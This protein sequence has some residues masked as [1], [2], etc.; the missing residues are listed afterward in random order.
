VIKF[1]GSLSQS[2]KISFI[3]G[4]VFIL[5]FTTFA[6]FWLLRVDYQVLFSD[7]KPQDSAVMVAELDRL[8]TPYRISE[9]G[10]AILVDKE[11]VHATRLKLLGKDL[12]L[13][14]V[15]GL[16]LFN[17]SDF[18]MT[19][20][21]QKINYQR[22]LQGEITRTISSLEEIQDVRVHLA[23]PEEGLFKR[24]T[25]K[26]KAAITITLK[27][28]YTL[29]SEQV[30]GIQ[31]L[32]AA[33]VPGIVAQ[34]VTIVDKKGVALT[35]PVGAVEQDFNVG[36]LELKKETEAL[37]SKKVNQILNGAFGENQT[38]AS[39]DVILNMDQIKVTMD[40]V[41]A[42]PTAAGQA[43]TGVIVK[44]KESSRDMAAP[45]DAAAGGQS[46]KSGTF[47]RETEYQVGR[48]S[49]QIVSQPGAIR[50]ISAVAVIHRELND[51]QKEQIKSLVSA[52][53][54]A[55]LERGDTII[56]QSTSDLIAKATI[57]TPEELV[58]LPE[59]MST[60]EIVKRDPGVVTELTSKVILILIVIIMLLVFFF[61]YLLAKAKKASKKTMNDEER[62]EALLK[63]KNWLA[64]DFESKSSQ[65]NRGV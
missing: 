43:P 50:R 47:L 53:V 51:T 17:N 20:F 10:N 24:A 60:P 33:A 13:H 18:G 28:G 19:E 46:A 37:L 41:L 3:C 29:R 2:A 14:G 40:D 9:G 39:V 35:R 64:G 26:A 38:S 55:N 54:G 22:A 63:I 11:I 61:L 56:I 25:S 31:R 6:G 52:A 44:D 59:K 8:K 45:L 30:T 48:R 27:P 65:Q 57:A 23:L 62:A 1:W 36:S 32:V 12:P 15:V 42:A 7:L 34:D 16:E 58:Q 49:E 5:A 4:L 21:A